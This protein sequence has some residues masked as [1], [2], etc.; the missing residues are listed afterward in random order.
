MNQVTAI[1]ISFLRPVYTIA[2]IQSLRRTYPGIQIIVG[3][4]GNFDNQ[5]A[6]VCEQ[7]GA[8][9]VQLPYDSGVCVG[10][11]TLMQ[12]VQTKYVLV[13]DDDF[14]YDENTGVNKMLAVLEC[15]PQVDLIGGRI[16]E[17]G[18]VRNYQGSI[19]ING[20]MLV[21]RPIDLETANWELA[22]VSEGQSMR[23]VKTDLVFNFFIARVDKVRD[24]PWDEEIKVAYE[25][26][27]WFIDLQKAQ[28]GVYFT[29][30][31]VIEH[32]PQ[33]LRDIVENSPAHATYKAFR[34]RRT[35]K[36]RFF[37][38]HQLDYVVDMN[39]VR[40]DA[41]DSPRVKR[42]DAIKRVDFCITTFKRPEAIKRLLFSIAQFYP[43][44]NIYVADQ[45][46]KFDREFY[47]NLR[48]DLLN[49]GLQ[50]RVSIEN[51]PYDCGLSYARN[52]LVTTTPNK[53][54]LIL[55]DDMVFIN[56]TSIEKMVALLE[57][58]PS[59][60]VVGGKVQQLGNDIHFEFTPEIVGDTIF[61]RKETLNWKK[62][63][64]TQYR[65]TGCVLNFALFRR[66]VFNS[67]LWD[68]ALKV[69]E[70]TDF[71]LRMKGLAW[72]ILYTPDVVID[73]PPTA[74]VEDYKQMRTREEFMRLMFNKHRVKRVVY[75]NGQT[76]ELNPDG[77]FTRYKRKP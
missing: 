69:T 70:H 58:C 39:G 71:Y 23:I 22:Y 62:H 41:P 55:D 13:G 26:E 12:H 46:E 5:L 31:A 10:R 67:I 14:Y 1:V 29:P 74:R 36:E 65:K 34:M 47:R 4:N 18:I 21:N 50:K 72:Q 3:E 73:H 33:H 32:K 27:S 59:A 28:I 9:Y 77:S 60:G 35:D 7:V 64:D 42:I 25:H 48:T 61:H 68:Q 2:C 56:K 51:L 37:R 8:K 38:R 76:V 49:A 40:D 63:N 20:R 6:K 53:Y 54:K 16:R 15:Q 11:N 45:N 75:E 52:H 57:A 19:E 17:N 43:S 30:D 24:I 44:A 66:E